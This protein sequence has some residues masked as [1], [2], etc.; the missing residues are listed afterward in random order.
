MNETIKID[1]QIYC[2]DCIESQHPEKDELKNKLIEKQFDPTIC[3][4]C[5]KDFLDLELNKIGSYPIC[6]DCEFI[7]KK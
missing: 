5:N 3:S 6:K 1:G 4:F 7:V 2:H